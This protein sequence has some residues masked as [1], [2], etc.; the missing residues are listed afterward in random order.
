LKI[1]IIEDSAYK[2]KIKSIESN[3]DVIKSLTTLEYLIGAI[4]IYSAI[5]D[6]LIDFLDLAIALVDLLL[7]IVY[8]VLYP[9]D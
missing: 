1:N 5:K 7:L 9:L 4:L 8:K 2:C 6:R 3:I